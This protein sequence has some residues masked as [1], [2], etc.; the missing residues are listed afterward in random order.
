[1]SVVRVRHHHLACLLTCT[2]EPLPGEWG[3]GQQEV[4]CSPWQRPTKEARGMRRS[5]WTVDE[6]NLTVAEMETEDNPVIAASSLAMGF[7]EKLWESH[8]MMLWMNSKLTGNE[9]KGEPPEWANIQK[10]PPFKW[11]PNLV[12]QI[13]SGAEPRV[14]LLGNP[15]IWRLN[16]AVLLLFPCLLLL[17]AVRTRDPAATVDMF[18]AAGAGAGAGARCGHLQ[19]ATLLFTLW[20]LH[21][22][23]FFFMLR[24]L[25]VHHYYPALYFSSLLTGVCLDWL[26]AALVSRWPLPPQLS[27]ALRFSFLVCFTAM[28][29]AS[30]LEFSPLVYGMRGD[31]AKFSNSTYHHLYWSDW[32]DF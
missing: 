24:V 30:F 20:A 10:Q 15:R 4:A 16:L 18:R 9:G 25:Y 22:L 23:P 29:A 28:L 11:P 19:A 32:W 13:F 14:Y 6:N 31:Q 5:T 26:L 17:R 1:M 3:F 27:P 12:S 7:W 8:R 21:Y 2:L